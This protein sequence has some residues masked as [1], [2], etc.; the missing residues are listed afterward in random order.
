MTPSEAKL[1]LSF[2][3]GRN[4]NIDN[5]LWENGFLG[6]L[7]PYRGKPNE[8]NF[9][10][11]IACLKALSNE[12]RNTKYLQKTIVADITTI[13][14]FG[15]A[16]AVSEDGM[17]RSNNLVQEIDWKTIEGWI[18]CISYAFA[19]LLDGTD[20]ETAFEPY[21]YEYES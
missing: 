2:H 7:R 21:T 14:H 8:N 6:S 10:D 12:I 17:L 15:R 4:S 1:R 5:P 16:W 11:V 13:I 19:C 18:E 9:H 3:S 20:D